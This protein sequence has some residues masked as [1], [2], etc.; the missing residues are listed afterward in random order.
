ME[1][2]IEC[3]GYQ[4]TTKLSL[5]NF[6]KGKKVIFMEINYPLLNYICMQQMIAGDP[7]TK[8][9]DSL[10]KMDR[11][12]LHTCVFLHHFHIHFNGSAK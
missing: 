9:R 8:A 11:S 4:S 5:I 2:L 6:E 10:R 1:F 3:S 12:A 7:L